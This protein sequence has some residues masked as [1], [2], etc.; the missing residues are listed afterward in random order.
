MAAEQSF[1]ALTV[2]TRKWLLTSIYNWATCLAYEQEAQTR[3]LILP[4]PEW[5]KLLNRLI[6][7]QGNLIKI[8]GPQGV[9]KTTFANWL[10]LNL[11]KAG[12]KTAFQKIRKSEEKESFGFFEKELT[13]EIYSGEIYNKL[14]KQWYWCFE[15]VE[16]IIIDLWDYSK[17]SERDIIKALD[18]LQSWWLMRA[19][20]RIEKKGNEVI[21]RGI[22]N[23]VI[24]LQKE[25][26]PLH[27]FLGKMVYFE[28]KPWKPEDLTGY[29]KE[30]LRQFAGNLGMNETF[31]FMEDALN[32][33]AILSRGIFRK[34]KEYLAACLD[35]LITEQGLDATKTITLNDVK[36][37]LTT[38]KLVQDMEL[39]LCELWPRNKDNRVFAVKLLRY[40]REHGPT[41]QKTIAAEIFDGNL[42]LC[43]RIINKLGEHAFLKVEKKAAEKIWSV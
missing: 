14:E 38:E 43:S 32:E 22:P 2:E 15:H 31:P 39:T 34:F 28:I 37:V 40:L 27:F 13:P 11:E 9:G 18:A 5:K 19:N 25:A 41:P 20:T 26:L 35:C 36:C 12:R 30:L 4:Q 16:N 29:Y 24:F 6:F 8:V 10:A 23:I 42:M 7:S 3:P 21:D 17:S 33:I 1:N